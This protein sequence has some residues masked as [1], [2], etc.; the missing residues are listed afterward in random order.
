M[1]DFCRSVRDLVRRHAATEVKSIGDAVMLHA[2]DAAVAIH[3]ARRIVDDVGSRHAFPTVRVGVHT[4]QAV[5]RDGDWFGSAVNIAARVVAVAAEREVL[6][7]AAAQQAA[8]GQVGDLEFVPAGERR[9]KNVAEPVTVFRVVHAGDPEVE[10]LPVDP[11]CRMV[12]DPARAA[13]RAT[14]RRREYLFCSEHCRAAF[15]AEP[16]RYVARR[17]FTLRARRGFSGS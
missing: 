14:H 8:A 11:V 10:G 4:G 17:R 7:T 12:I 15:V 16:S 1:G 9:L 2:G 13:A 5:E 6:A 3:L